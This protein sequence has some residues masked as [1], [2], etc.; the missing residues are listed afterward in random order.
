MSPDGKWVTGTTHFYKS[1]WA[2]DRVFQ[3]V[4]LLAPQDFTKDLGNSYRSVR[5]TLTYIGS[6]EWIWLQRWNGTS[7]HQMFDPRSILT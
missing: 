6:A 3:T 2:N 5:D 7:P 4:A 1:Q